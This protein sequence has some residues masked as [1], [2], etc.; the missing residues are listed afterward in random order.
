MM[1]DILGID[2]YIGFIFVGIGIL[3]MTAIV[4]AGHID[5]KRVGN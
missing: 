3:C 1:I 2:V 4:I 5:S